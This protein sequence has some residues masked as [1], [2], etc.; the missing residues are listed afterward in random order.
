[1]QELY[2]LDLHKEIIIGEELTPDSLRAY[3]EHLHDQVF[4][5]SK[6]RRAQVNEIVGDG[7]VKV[8]VKCACGE[9]PKHKGRP[10]K[11][12]A[13]KPYGNGWFMLVNP[14]NLRILAVTCMDKPEDNA[15]VRETLAKALPYYK[16]LSAFILDR[17]CAFVPSA[18][19]DSTLKQIK[20]WGVDTFHAQKHKKSCP[21][22]PL[23]V[24][25]LAKRCKGV[26]MS[27]AEQV[28]SWFRN[29]ARLL[30]ETRPL[31]HV[32]KVLHFIKEH[33]EAI[34]CKKALYL[35]KYNAKTKTKKSSKA[36]ACAKSPILKKN[37]KKSIVKK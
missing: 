1:M 16:N 26:N 35:N 2:V 21:C 12:G 32:F 4:P 3:D 29:Y 5:P 7:H 18:A 36:Y 24:R 37:M 34:D 11:N 25:R 22:N 10:R 15:V 13:A 6:H 31:R 17:A 9:P 19:H 20:Y 14:K 33:N 23:Y 30:N 8:H 28:F 27:A